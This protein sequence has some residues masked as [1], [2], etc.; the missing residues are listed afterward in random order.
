MRREGVGWRGSRVRSSFWTRLCTRTTTYYWKRWEKSA[1]YEELVVC[2]V[3][4]VVVAFLMKMEVM[5]DGKM[6]FGL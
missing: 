5:E 1:F 6:V 2:F 4:V 3:V